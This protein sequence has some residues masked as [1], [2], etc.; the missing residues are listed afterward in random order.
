MNTSYPNSGAA[1]TSAHTSAHTSATNPLSLDAM[2]A[3]ADLLGGGEVVAYRPVFAHIFGGA[4]AALLLSQFWFW[5][6]TPTVKGRTGNGWFWKSQKEITEETGLTRR[7]TETAR[8]KLTALGVLQEDLRGVPATLHFRLDKERLFS[9]LWEHLQRQAPPEKP[10][11]TKEIQFVRNRQTGLRKTA[12]LDCPKRENLLARKG[13][14]TSETTLE[15]TQ[16]KT[17]TRAERLSPAAVPEKTLRRPLPSLPDPLTG[18]SETD[19]AMLEAQARTQL[20]T[21]NRAPV[22]DSLRQGRS[23][24]LVKQRMRELMASRSQE[25]FVGATA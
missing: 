20:L 11:P 22:S 12:K 1:S 16:E 8:R 18:L 5:T 10:E 21:E 15:K 9:L 23:L 3:V 17:L 24:R 7:E 14:T 2:K 6:N 19:F 13:Q 25:G 4:T